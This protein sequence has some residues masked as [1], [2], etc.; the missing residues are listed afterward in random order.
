MWNSIPERWDQA[1]CRGFFLHG[2]SLW[3]A[4]GVDSAGCRLW[5]LQ[6]VGTSIRV[7]CLAPQWGTPESLSMGQMVRAQWQP[8]GTGKG[9]QALSAGQ[10]EQ[11][12]L[13][14]MATTDT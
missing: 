8:L 3:K 14:S 10:A 9:H 4:L 11:A 12:A 7:R 2:Q 5:T 13:T 6:L 1:P